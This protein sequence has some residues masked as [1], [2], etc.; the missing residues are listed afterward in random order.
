M[1]QHI[2]LWAHFIL[3]EQQQPTQW[4]ISFLDCF[5]FFLVCEHIFVF[6]FMLVG[7]FLNSPVALYC[8]GWKVF[9]FQMFV[10]FWGLL[11]CCCCSL[12]FYIAPKSKHT[13]AHTTQSNKPSTKSHTILQND[14][15]CHSFILY[16]SFDSSD[17]LCVSVWVCS[18]V[19]IFL[20][21]S[22]AN[23]IFKNCIASW[24]TW[25]INIK[26]YLQKDPDDVAPKYCQPTNRQINEPTNKHTHTQKMKEG[27]ER[28][29]HRE[30]QASE[31]EQLLSSNEAQRKTDPTKWK[32]SINAPK[33]RP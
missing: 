25:E 31:Q 7:F 20:T 22:C 6:V 21:N 32:M 28:I 2:N 27:R 8:I 17:A 16:S 4:C 5:F 13:E 19:C 26:L 1:E 11:C 15:C 23:E 18:C 14:M 24:L 33:T 29:W 30:R 10:I 12:C 9:F 3:Y